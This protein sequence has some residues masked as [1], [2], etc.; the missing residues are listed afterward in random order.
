ME[1]KIGIVI[2]GASEI[3]FRRFFPALKKDERFEYIGVAYYRE[4]DAEFAK[5]FKETYGGEIFTSFETAIND[6]RVDAVYV[7]Q[8]PA[9][10]H[11]YGKMV[12]EAGK[13]LFMEK[14]FTTSLED[15]K[16]LVEL[17][18]EKDLAVIENYMFRF[19]KQISEFKRIAESGIL[20]E[21]DHY[22]TRFSFPLRQKNDF[23]YVKE[24]GGGA[25][26]D[27]GGYPIYLGNILTDWKGKLVNAELIYED[28]YEV[29]MHGRGTL[30]VESGPSCHC[31]FGMNDEYCCYAK[32]FGS[33]GTLIAPRVLTAPADMDVK[34]SI[35]WKDG[36]VE[37]VDVGTDD[38]FLKSI[39][40][41]HDCIQNKE[42]R[43]DSFARIL[44]QAESIEAMKKGE[45]VYGSQNH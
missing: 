9:L 41:F 23:R 38:S 15:S 42:T 8:P 18:K 37:E 20:G 11:R 7:P 40:Y 4:Q 28:G 44:R 31:S 1:R 25:L 22:E 19:H 14:P 26:L 43:E 5:Q 29:D 21:I 39:G 34:F 30:L 24:L 32:A 35:E 27:C 10:H 12:L 33:K 3:A 17:A 2:L 36:N 13:H 6:P 45:K 16:E